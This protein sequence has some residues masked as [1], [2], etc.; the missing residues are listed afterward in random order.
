MEIRAS[1]IASSVINAI[2]AN[3]NKLTSQG[4]LANTTVLGTYFQAR[5]AATTQSLRRAP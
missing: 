3:R 5:T 2:G 1:G 4:I